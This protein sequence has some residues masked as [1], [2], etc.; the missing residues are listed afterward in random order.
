VRHLDAS[1]SEAERKGGVQEL[2]GVHFARV[3]KVRLP[4]LPMTGR[5]A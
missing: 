2:L 5:A 1:E 4:H 3:Y